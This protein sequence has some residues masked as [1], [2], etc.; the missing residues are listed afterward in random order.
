MND[1]DRNIY[2]IKAININHEPSKNIKMRRR[3]KH[4]CFALLI[5]FLTLS[6][7][8]IAR[9][10]EV[11]LID[12]DCANQGSLLESVYIQDQRI[13][14]SDIPFKEFVK[15]DHENLEI[16]ISIIEKCGMP[17]LDDVS[18]RQINAMWL[19][20]QHAQDPK[21]TQKYF[22][23][24]EQAYENGDLTALHFATMRDRILMNKGRHQIYGTQ[25]KNGKLYKLI[26][27]EYVNARRAKIG[28]GSIQ[29][30][31]AHYNI[32]FNVKQKDLQ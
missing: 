3:F 10:Q 20:L 17:T 1:Y 25:I 22:P 15:V 13:R 31:L 4:T 6:C 19:A 12:V 11:K 29:E 9:I 32:S 24:I 30:Y 23:V 16:V 21:Y 2:R 5:I 8:K 18:R 27:P 7:D 26:N 14:S 28:L